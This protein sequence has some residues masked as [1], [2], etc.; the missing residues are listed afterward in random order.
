MLVIVELWVVEDGHWFTMPS[1]GGPWSASTASVHDSPDG[2]AARGAQPSVV[3]QGEGVGSRRCSIARP[4]SDL[5]D[6]LSDAGKRREPSITDCERV[7]APMGSFGPAGTSYSP[8]G[9]SRRVLAVVL[10]TGGL[11]CTPQSDSLE[12]EAHGVRPVHDRAITIVPE[13]EALAES[14]PVEDETV[15]PGVQESTLNPTTSARPRLAVRVIEDGDDPDDLAC[16]VEYDADDLPAY[17]PAAD[18]VVVVETY[19]QGMSNEM[20]LT[21]RWRDGETGDTNHTVEVVTGVG[22][23]PCKQLRRRIRRRVAE[24]N[25][26]LAA[27]TFESMSAL[28]VRVVHPDSYD[29]YRAGLTD[30][31]MTPEDNAEFREEIMPR[32]QMHIVDTKGDTLLRL[33]GVKVYER[34]VLGGE[35]TR[36]LDSVVAHHPSGTVLLTQAG[37]RDEE[38]CTCNREEESTVLRWSAES[39]AAAEKYRCVA[40]REY[41]DD[42]HVGSVYF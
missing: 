15:E 30:P 7:P 40:G 35:G 16:R 20:E 12:L 3:H 13:Q 24:V 39:I 18:E 10:V 27:G 4:G 32:G 1:A 9:G 23:I 19:Q 31:D 41:S 36:T 38:D 42:C 26:R 21:V 8:M 6:A 28:P 2:K 25:Q 33:P 14:P 22:G 5:D 34:F 17:D 29:N 37:C 11:A